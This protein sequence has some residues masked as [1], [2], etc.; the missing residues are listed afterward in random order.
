MRVFRKTVFVKTAVGD[1][2]HLS[3]DYPHPDDHAKNIS[4]APGLKP[5]TV[6]KY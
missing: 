4:G 2:N 3:Q 5:F 1:N 6:K